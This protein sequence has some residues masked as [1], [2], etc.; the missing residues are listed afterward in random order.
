MFGK[1]T[2]L[3]GFAALIMAVSGSVA[4]AG[5]RFGVFGS[6]NYTMPT[7]TGTT[8]TGSRPGYGAGALVELPFGASRFGLQLDSRYQQE[9][10]SSGT[11]NGVN[12]GLSFEFYLN[13]I[14]SL[15]LGG[16]YNYVLTPVPA[17]LSSAGQYG[18]M[19]GLGFNIPFSNVVALMID[20]R[21]SYALSNQASTGTLNPHNI[22]GFVGLKFGAMGK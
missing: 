12:T 16:F 2:K 3:L 1:L 8:V 6:A 10:Y 21:Y 9:V 22:F 14:F 13:R 4:Q 20:T 18:A 7:A 17:G 5:P 15:S 11:V 19:G